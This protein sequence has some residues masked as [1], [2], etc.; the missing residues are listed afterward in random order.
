MRNLEDAHNT[1]ADY[2]R[3]LEE[4]IKK[5]VKEEGLA[6]HRI[7]ERLKD[8]LVSII[9]GNPSLLD[10]IA[11]VVSKKDR[12]VLEFMDHTRTYSPDKFIELL[13]KKK[14]NIR[15][16]GYAMVLKILGP[17][18]LN[19]TLEEIRL[20]ALEDGSYD[21]FFGEDDDGVF[22]DHTE[23][24]GG[25]CKGKT[26][27]LK[28]LGCEKCNEIETWTMYTAFPQKLS[29]KLKNLG[30]NLEFILEKMVGLPN[31]KPF[32]VKGK[33]RMLRYRSG[34]SNPR[35]DEPVKNFLETRFPDLVKLFFPEET[36]QRRW[37]KNLHLYSRP[38]SR[39]LRRRGY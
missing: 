39:K 9:D 32:E 22:F 5:W 23:I 19:P 36:A 18:L 14:T 17:P 37:R 26:Y 21:S 10:E 16:A 28:R 30:Q 2:P 3:I 8:E 4:P 29:A 11:R 31:W 15:T 35:Y 6:P 12:Q 25:S 34:L 33:P 20:L 27:N 38:T 24:T 7:V 13:D 1:L